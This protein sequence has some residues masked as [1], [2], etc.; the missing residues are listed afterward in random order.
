MSEETKTNLRIAEAYSTVEGILAEKDLKVVTDTEGKKSIRGTIVVKVDETNS[1]TYNIWVNELNSNGEPNRAFPG[2]TTV[3]DEYA[4]IAQ[5]GLDD[6]TRLTIRRGEFRPNSYVGKDGAV[7]TGVRYGASF[8]SRFSPRD[9]EMFN[10]KAEFVVE[11]FI[12]VI[13]PEVNRDGEETGRLKIK[14]F[15]PTYRGVEPLELIVPEDMADDFTSAL[16]SGQTSK[17]YGQIVNRTI[18]KDR[19]IKLA[20][21]GSRTVQDRS[22]IN[23][24]VL[25][26]AEEAYEDERAYDMEAIKKGLVEREMRLEKEK[27]DAKKKTTTPNKQSTTTGRTLPKFTGFADM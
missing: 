10:P 24:L 3:M 5:V 21:G 2:M 7:H 15:V 4:S 25:T 22:W 18:V 12:N 23:E 27:E 20:V 6:A 13:S 8:I 14:I 11:G 1:V 17:F 19:T 26:G 16:D 9:G